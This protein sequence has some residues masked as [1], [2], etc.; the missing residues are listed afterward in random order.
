MNYIEGKIWRIVY[1][2]LSSGYGKLFRDLLQTLAAII[3]KK[4]EVFTPEVFKKQQTKNFARA[5]D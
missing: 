1:S 2:N 5:D 4:P 3:L